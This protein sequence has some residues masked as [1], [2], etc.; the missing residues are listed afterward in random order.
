MPPQKYVSKFNV[1]WMKDEELKSWLQP[2]PKSSYIG[3]CSI[4]KVN[5]HSKSIRLT[6]VK[7]HHK[8]EKHQILLSVALGKASTISNFYQTTKRILSNIEIGATENDQGYI[9]QTIQCIEK[10]KISY[11]IS[12]SGI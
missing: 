10:P 11:K 12:I 9:I 6:A 5:I 2:D 4:C 3:Q 7:K 1:L 8:G